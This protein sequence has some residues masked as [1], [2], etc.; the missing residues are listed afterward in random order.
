MALLRTLGWC[1][2]L[3]MVPLGAVMAAWPDQLTGLLSQ[4]SGLDIT[5][6]QLAIGFLLIAALC[7]RID[8][9]IRRRHAAG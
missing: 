8:L 4:L 6:G 7:M 3:V 2:L 9:Q 5:R 1:F